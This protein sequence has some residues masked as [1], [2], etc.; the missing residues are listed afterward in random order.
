MNTYDITEKIIVTWERRLFHLFSL[1]GNYKKCRVSKE[2]VSNDPLH[3]YFLLFD[4]GLLHLP[5]LF[6]VDRELNQVVLTSLIPFISVYLSSGLQSSSLHLGD[7]VSRVVFMRE[8]P[9]TQ[10]VYKT[11]RFY[12]IHLKSQEQQGNELQVINRIKGEGKREVEWGFYIQ[13]P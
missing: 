8:Y 13:N 6:G 1:N 5:L 9:Y 4:L 7:S 12:L 11:K 3:T 10:P 2:L